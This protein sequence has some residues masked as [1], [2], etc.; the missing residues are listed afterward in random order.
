MTSKLLKNTDIE[1]ILRRV[2]INTLID[3]LIEKLKTGFS[4]L[5]K[6]S[7][8]IPARTGIHYSNPDI[9]LLEWMPASVGDGTV[10]LKIV[11][12]HPSNPEQNGL[13]TILSSLCVFD[14]TSGHLRGIMDGTFPTA[15]RTGA[16]SALAT[17]LMADS[18]RASTLGIIGCGAQSVTQCHALSRTL[19]IDK[20]IA[21]DRDPD[22][23]ASLAQRIAFLEIPVEVVSVSNLESLLE[24]SDILCTCTS[25]TPGSGPLFRDFPNK[26]GLHVNAVGSDFPDKYELPVELLQRSVVIPDFREQALVEGECQQ[27]EPDKVTHDLTSLLNVSGLQKH[28]KTTLSVFDSTGH[29]YADYLTGLL[30]MQHAHEM[31]IGSDIELECTPT[32]PKNPY[33]FLT[34]ES[35]P[36][37]HAKEA[38]ASL[39]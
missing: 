27:L 8:L 38:N 28:C 22:S 12:Y 3:Q 14:S 15:L 4:Q 21:Y 13:P 32:D 25:E 29:A 30:F 34:K 9:G 39:R 20:I 6:D 16:M 35:L 26:P 24:R 10:S 1:T 5:N 11:G 17:S 33:S 2:G 36:E 31:R 23:A 19:P 37:L 7:S 18:T